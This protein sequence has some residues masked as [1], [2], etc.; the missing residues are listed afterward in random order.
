M[1]PFAVPPTLVRTDATVNFNWI[2]TPPAASI[3]L[4]NFCVRWRGSIQPEYSETYTFT[5]DT[6]SGVRLYVN[7]QLL[8]N[9]WVNQPATAWSNTITLTAQQRYNLE[10]DFY[11]QIGGAQAQLYWSSPSTPNAII[12]QTQLYPVTNPPPAVVLTSPA[13]GSTFTASATVSLSADADAMYNP[14][15]FVSFYTNGILVGSVSNAPYAFTVTGLVAWSY[16]LTAT[17]TDGSGLTGTSAPVAVTV[18]AASGLPYGLITNATLVAFLNQK[19]PGSFSGTIPALLSATGAFADTPN[20]IPAGG[21]IT[22]LPNTPLWYDNAVKS[23]YLAL[24]YSGGLIP[25]GAAN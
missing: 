4:T 9:E 15:S 5:T 7:G 11:N 19:M 16:T 20:R 24:P 3:G 13:S 25:P 14:L 10:M 22:Y 23:R 2:T 8:I 1:C 18:N 12:P 21:L 17:A 6:D